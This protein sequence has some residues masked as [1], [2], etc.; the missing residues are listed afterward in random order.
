VCNDYFKSI[1]D[2]TLKWEEISSCEHYHSEICYNEPQLV[3]E[4]ESRQTQSEI[5][6]NKNEESISSKSSNKSSITSLDNSLVEIPKIT[7]PIGK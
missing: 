2:N 7:K 4:Q 5:S 6:V 3:I 1:H